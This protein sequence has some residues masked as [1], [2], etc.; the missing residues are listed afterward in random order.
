MAV[1]IRISL[2]DLLSPDCSLRSDRKLR[3][4]PR[5]Q[6]LLASKPQDRSQAIEEEFFFE[7][8]MTAIATAKFENFLRINVK[9]NSPGGP[10]STRS[11]LVQHAETPGAAW[12][13]ALLADWTPRPKAYVLLERGKS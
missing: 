6:F 10:Q 8:E 13:S 9:Y 2:V 11:S 12:W 5:S 1:L 4:V 7:A 3:I